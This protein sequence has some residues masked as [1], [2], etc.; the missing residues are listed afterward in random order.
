MSDIK[1]VCISTTWCGNCKLLK[2]SLNQR[3][4]QYD[5]IDVDDNP[6]EAIRLGI[7]EI[8]V[9]IAYDGEKEVGRYENSSGD[10]DKWLNQIKGL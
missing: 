3:G 2:A 10:L 4:I 8:P 1:L 5:I 6:E 9:L 7:E